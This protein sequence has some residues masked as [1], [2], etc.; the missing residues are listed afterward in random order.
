VREISAEIEPVFARL[1][2]KYRTVELDI[3]VAF[4]CLPDSYGRRSF[5]RY[6]KDDITL[7]L[8]LTVSDTR[9]WLREIGWLK[10]EWEI[11]LCAPGPTPDSG[12]ES[13]LCACLHCILR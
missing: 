8:D 10:E 1:A 13:G 2:G 11:Y 12:P 7:V 4:R 3:L 6:T 9:D 5:R